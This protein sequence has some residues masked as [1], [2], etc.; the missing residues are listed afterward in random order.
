MMDRL[1][2][3]EDRFL[4]SDF[5]APVLK[6]GKVHVRIASVVCRL[7]VEPADFEGWGV[8]RPASTSAARLLRRAGLA[9]I[10]RYLELFPRLTVI[11]VG[12]RNADWVAVP[13]HQADQRFRFQGL[14]P[15]HF[16]EEGQP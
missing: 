12:R 8:F 16:V 10:Q 4:Q 6:G 9:E 11:L 14:V 13:A 15:I 3:A 7:K 2:A 5:L 1:A